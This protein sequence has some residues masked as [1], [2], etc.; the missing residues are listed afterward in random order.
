[1][2]TDSF[3][4]HII[5][6]EVCEDIADDVKRR[7]Y[8]SNFEVD[9]P[10]STRKNKKAIGLMKHELEGNIITVFVALR[11]KAY[12]HLMNYGNSHKKIRC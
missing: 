8:T 4:I 1:M 5:T 11:P 3:L 6:K 7:F 12:S 10:Q 2:D 9:R